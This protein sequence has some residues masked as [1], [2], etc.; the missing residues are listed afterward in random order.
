M[1]RPSTP[2]LIV[3]MLL[4]GRF[5]NVEAIEGIR[6]AGGRNG[7]SD[8]ALFRPS[9]G[10]WYILNSSTNDAT[11]VSLSWGL[12][13]DV[14]VPADYDGDG[15]TDPAVYRASTGQWFILK[16]STNYTASLVVLWG[17]I[18]DVPLQGDYDGDG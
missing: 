18:T 10:T 3:V 14:P 8:P 9:T 15:K 16:S 4:S 17:L 13:T 1:I 5:A 7:K 6:S 12:G 2:C 11:S